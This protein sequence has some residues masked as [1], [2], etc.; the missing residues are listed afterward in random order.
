MNDQEAKD[1]SEWSGFF[2]AEVVFYSSKNIRQ[3]I[4]DLENE[5]E[6]RDGAPQE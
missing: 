6:L 5:L 3:M 1:Y 4:Q 2:A